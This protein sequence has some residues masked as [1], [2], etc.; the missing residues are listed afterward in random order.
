MQFTRLMTNKSQK[1]LVKA[2]RN[3][4]CWNTCEVLIQAKVI[5]SSRH[6]LGKNELPSTKF[7]I[8]WWLVRRKNELSEKFR[9][10]ALT[11]HYLHFC[12]NVHI[13]YATR[14]VAICIQQNYCENAIKMGGSSFATI[15]E[16]LN[17]QPSSKYIKANAIYTLPNRLSAHFML[18]RFFVAPVSFNRISYGNIAEINSLLH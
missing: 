6:E 4:K 9:V 7:L 18:A 2:A 3:S 16:H 1:N 14:L 13:G 17:K 10:D 11:P 15:I 5:L 12:T 8:S